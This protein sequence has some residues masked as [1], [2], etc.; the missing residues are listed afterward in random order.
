MLAHRR[1]FGETNGN[2]VPADPL[3]HPLAKISPLT[4]PSVAPSTSPLRA[5]ATAATSSSS[6]KSASDVPSQT[7]KTVVAKMKGKQS[8]G[9][10]AIGLELILVSCAAH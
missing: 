10:S 6:S 3:D 7:R 2:L 4:K 5:V 1:R 9:K 8:P